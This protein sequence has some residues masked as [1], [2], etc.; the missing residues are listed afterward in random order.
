MA[1][2]ISVN[3]LLA[4]N[5]LASMH[6]ALKFCRLVDRQ[7]DNQFIKSQVNGFKPGNSFRINRPARY[8]SSTGA[9]IG[10]S[11]VEDMVEDPIYMTV[12]DSDRRKIVNQFD[13]ATMTTELTNEKSRIGDPQGLQL[14][15][16]I[17]K[18]IVA[19]CL[20]GVQNGFVAVGNAT[21]GTKIGTEDLLKAQAYLDTLTCPEM[22]RSVLIPPFT[23]AQLSRENLNLFT[24]TMN[25]NI[26]VKGF[27]KEF[28]GADMFRY[29]LL[30]TLSIPALAGAGSVTTTVVDGASSVAVTF[31]AQTATKVFPAGTL[32]SFTAERVNPE[33]RESIGLA[34]TF[35]S[36]SAFTI[37]SGGGSVTIQIDEASKIYGPADNGNRQ[38]IVS[39][40]TSGSAVTILG[41]K[42][43]S[44]TDTATVFD[45]VL[46]FNKMA[47][48]AA[49]IPLETDLPGA[50][51]SRADYDGMSLRVAKQYVNGSDTVVTRFDVWGKGISQ[52]DQ[53]SV[54]ILVPQA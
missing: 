8:A 53:Y 5:A 32:L 11:D 21:L 48:S 9:A 54:K 4:K 19:E 49:M 23:N 15:T 44:V 14:A 51:A 26:A 20:V 29:N 17:E 28:A 46:M 38:N 50:E 34:Y 1:N 25:E 7:L 33:T 43:S 30:P 35:A 41:A 22:E 3:Q 12:A 13:S 2:V 42:N 45:Q 31:V 40:P 27:V 16:D 36:K 10:G 24:P 52:R 39:L 6:N 37:P 47:F 18:K